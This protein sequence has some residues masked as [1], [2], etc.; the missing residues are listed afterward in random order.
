MTSPAIDNR[1][2]LGMPVFRTF[3]WKI[4]KAVFRSGLIRNN[5][6]LANGRIPASRNC[7]RQ[8][9]QVVT[10]GSKG[11][12]SIPKNILEKLGIRKG[13]PMLIEASADGAIV[14]RQA[15]IYPLEIYSDDRVR[16]FDE[17]D[18]LSVSERQDLAA[19]EKRAP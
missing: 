15:G 4:L 2:H 5:I 11:Q 10:V 8:I 18:R 13:T 1:H 17:S 3:E 7:Y 19:A 6:G 9:M 16:E 14:L 12:L